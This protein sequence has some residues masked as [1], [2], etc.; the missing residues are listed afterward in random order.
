MDALSHLSSYFLSGV[1]KSS[2]AVCLAMALSKLCGPNKVNFENNRWIK[3]F[4]NYSGKSSN[5]IKLKI[6]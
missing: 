6:Y 3:A 4:E 5:I 2:V 1:G